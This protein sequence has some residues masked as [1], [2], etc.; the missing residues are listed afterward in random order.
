MTA[1][2]EKLPFSRPVKLNGLPPVPARPP[3]PLLQIVPPGG[4]PE[5]LVALATPM[6]FALASDA[7]GNRKART[8]ATTLRTF[9]QNL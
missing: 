4:V 1:A 6:M 2:R 7:S 3:E 8:T 5:Q 9:A